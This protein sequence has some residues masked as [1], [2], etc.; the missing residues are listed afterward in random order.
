M[1]CGGLSSWQARN[2]SRPV[3]CLGTVRWVLDR[4]GFDSV[5]VEGPI[6]RVDFV[7]EETGDSTFEMRQA[8]GAIE[9]LMLDLDSKGSRDKSSN[10]EEAETPFV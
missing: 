10:V 7:S 9:D 3:P 2:M 6:K 8:F 5:E 1:C 4:A